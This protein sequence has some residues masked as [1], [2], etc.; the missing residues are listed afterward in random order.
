MYIKFTSS[1]SIFDPLFYIKFYLRCTS[2]KIREAE[3]GNSYPIITP[4]YPQQTGLGQDKVRCHPGLSQRWHGRI[5]SFSYYLLESGVRMESGLKHKYSYMRNGC[6]KQHLNYCVKISSLYI[7]SSWKWQ[8]QVKKCLLLLF[9][10]KP[11][12]IIIVHISVQQWNILIHVHKTQINSG[13]AAFPLLWH[14]FKIG[15]LERC[16]PTC[17][18]NTYYVIMNYK[19]STI[20]AAPETYSFNLSLIWYPFSNVPL[21]LSTSRTFGNHHSML[22]WLQIWGKYVVFLLLCFFFISDDMLQFQP[23]CCRQQDFAIL[24]GWMIF[25]FTCALHLSIH[26]IMDTLF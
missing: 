4:K 16:L 2:W 19:H 9:I 18:Q 7:F 21:S 24:Y 11:F 25:H 17:S 6:T 10:S 20:H 1:K 5:L 15:A 23:F 13:L 8:N 12:K 26:M 22:D 3:I 14:Y